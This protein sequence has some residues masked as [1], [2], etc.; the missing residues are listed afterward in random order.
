MSNTVT[1][2]ENELTTATQPVALRELFLVFL[3]IG[4][5]SFG[6][7]MSLISVIETIVIKR[8]KLLEHRE[9]LDGI[10][11]ANLLPGP[12][13]VNIVA[14]IGYR[15]RGGLGALTAATAVLIPSFGLMLGLSYLY[16][17]YG[18]LT[19]ING[20]FHGFI[21]AVAAIVISV[22]VRLGK[23][24]ITGKSEFIIAMIAIVSLSIIPQ[25]YRLYMPFILIAL[26]AFTGYHL[27]QNQAS[28]TTAT[29]NIPQISKK[30]L[31]AIFCFF[32]M[33]FIL[34]FFP[35]PIDKHSPIFL[36]LT[37][38]S[39][40]LML[41]GGGYVFIPI[42]GSIVVLEYGWLT[43]QEFIDGIALGQITPG[44]ILTSATFIGYKVAGL[45]GAILSTIAIFFVP[46]LLM[47]TASLGLNYIRQS[48][49]LQAAMHGIHCVVIGMIVIA[50][51][52]IL[53]TAFPVWPI[54]IEHAW[55]VVVIFF[56]ALIALLKYN[57]DVVW[58]IPPAGFLGYL[59]F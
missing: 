8:H 21:P 45:S 59:F 12:M 34:W 7:F 31:V 42:I 2:S 50:A 55:P 9:L 32:A 14:Y 51:V 44:P 24:T 20:I 18:H 6:G 11:L 15:L 49:G 54:S 33:L 10:A 39:M 17:E 43:Q 28:I 27:Y 19:A 53:H 56:T 52:Y 48:A 26:A 36:A 47:I 25:A 1:I 5:I 40:S 58:I 30:K 29:A 35:L 3:K 38:G 13:A 22:V 4:S 23:K 46:A 37:F 57:L 41:F 16:F